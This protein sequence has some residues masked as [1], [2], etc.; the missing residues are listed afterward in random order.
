MVGADSV[1][2]KLGSGK[3]KTFICEELTYSFAYS[4][5]SGTRSFTYDL[6][7]YDGYDKIT[8]E[9]ITGGIYRVQAGTMSTAQREGSASFGEVTGYDS[10]TGIISATIVVGNHLGS[11]GSIVRVTPCFYIVV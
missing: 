9:D 6:S 3:I 4:T 2:K 7:T 11:G 1:P 10:E 8:A 5:P